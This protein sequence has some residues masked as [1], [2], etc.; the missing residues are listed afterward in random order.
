MQTLAGPVP[1]CS[2]S[3]SPFESCLIYLVDHVLL[4]SFVP[5]DFL[6]SFLPFC[7]VPGASKEGTGWRPPIETSSLHNVCCGSL[8]SL[9]LAAGGSL[10]I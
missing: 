9:P 10:S 5:S 6:Q 1:A 8:D 3:V 7:K 4:V 2:V